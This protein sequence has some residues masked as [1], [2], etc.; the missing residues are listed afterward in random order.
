MA[1]QANLPSWRQR[2]VD[3]YT[4]IDAASLQ[5]PVLVFI[6]NCVVFSD[7]LLRLV[8]FEFDEVEVVRLSEIAEIER[9]DPRMRDAIQ[10]VIVDETAAKSLPGVAHELAGAATGAGAVLAYRTVKIAREILEVSHASGSPGDLRFLPM[11][12]PIDAWLAALR[13]LTLGEAFVPSELL[14]VAAVGSRTSTEDQTAAGDT[15][16]A[17]E[18]DGETDPDSPSLTAR[19]AQIL[20]L[21]A[22]G[23]RNKTIAAKLG[24]SEHTVKLHVHHIFGKLG[25]GNRTSATRWYLSQNQ[26]A[27]SREMDSHG[28]R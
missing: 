19:E 8:G 2:D 15:F 12:A 9:L 7:R 17:P 4:K 10:L 27:C 21:V 18:T 23:K 24:L 26:G 28:N 6:G 16:Q 5:K 13:L 22:Q 1:Y 25:V 3:N 14:S 11:K 20:A